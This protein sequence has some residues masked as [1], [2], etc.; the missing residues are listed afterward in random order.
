MF[1]PLRRGATVVLAAAV[2]VAALTVAGPT[3]P[4]QAAPSIAANGVQLLVNN[5][6]GKCVEVEGGSR[7]EG[8]R[9]QQWA[10]G[11]ADHRRW[12]AHDLG[13]GYVM[14]ANR[15]SGLC[16]TALWGSVGV[17]QTLCSA[18]DQRQWWRWLPANATGELVLANP[19]PW[20]NSCL[21]LRPF[22]WLDG[23]VIGIADCAT[24]SA[25]L[26]HPVLL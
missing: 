9:I 3:G 21:A 15:N 14:Y 17:T 7:S 25:Q 4:A 22:S 24:T 2:T 6:S 26:W 20:G 1:S 16:L 13:N 10:C 8:A 18:S 12:T 19:T 23:R 5:V 11:T